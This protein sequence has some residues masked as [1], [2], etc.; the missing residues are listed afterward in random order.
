M[1]FIFVRERGS[2]AHFYVVNHGTRESIEIFELDAT[3]EP[4]VRWHGCLILPGKVV[5]NSV[6]PLPDGGIVVAVSYLA[7][8]TGLVSKVEKGENTGYVLEW[9]AGEGWKRVPGSAGS[10]PNGIE[11]SSDGHWLYVTNT[12]NKNVLRLSRGTKAVQ[13]TVIPTNLLTDNLRW[14]ARGQLWVA[15]QMGRCRF[16]TPVCAEPYA[17]LKLDPKTLRLAHVDHPPT[18]PEFGAASVALPVD[19]DVWVGTFLGD[20]IARFPSQN[21]LVMG[22]GAAIFHDHCAGCHE[23]STSGA[24]AKTAL[25]FLTAGTIYD[26]LT[27]GR[28]RGQAEVLSERERHQVAEYLA[29]ERPIDSGGHPLKRCEP[30][31]NWFDRSQGS[32]GTGWGIDAGNTRLIPARQGD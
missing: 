11:V 21:H 3:Q 25:R 32:V 14:D 10:F 2:S 28:M 29:S 20:R 24:P 17:I 18:G 7:D 8:D 30:D 4:K 26:I 12:G 15:A 5:G 19:D 31:A 27:T 9:H 22:P 13:K 16:D 6:A 23:S 1:A